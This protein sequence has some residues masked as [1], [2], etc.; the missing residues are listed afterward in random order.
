MGNQNRKNYTNLSTFQGKG[1]YTWTI[2]NWKSCTSN[3]DGG[4]LDV[5]DVFIIPVDTEGELKKPSRWQIMAFPVK[6][7]GESYLALALKCLEPTHLVPYGSFYFS[8]TYTRFPRVALD[9]ASGH[10]EYIND[11]LHQERD[12]TIKVKIKIVCF[13]RQT[14]I[15]PV[16][17][18]D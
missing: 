9:T 8:T 1:Q 6:H 5:S 2:P 10:T 11:H 18:S 14:R 12:L 16:C 7:D 15:N 13:E 4:R 3:P 17:P